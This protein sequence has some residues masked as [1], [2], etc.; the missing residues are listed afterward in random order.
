MINKSIQI[1]SSTQLYGVFG[2]PVAHSLSPVM[3]NRAFAET[4]VNGAYLA[5]EVTDIQAAVAGLRALGMRGASVTIPHKVRVM[6]YLDSVDETAARIGAVNTIVNDNGF[7]K[8]YNSD[9]LGAV[10][11][12][13]EKTPLNG[14]DVTILGAGGAA[15][16]IGFAVT[17]EGARVTVVNRTEERGKRL[18]REL[19]ADFRPLTGLQGLECEVL[20]NTTSVG[21]AP[22]ID[23]LPFDEELIERRALVMDIVYNPLK[24]KLLQR[25]EAIGCSTIDGV[26]MFVYQGGF[27]FELWTGR[28]APLA[29]MRRTVVDALTAAAVRNHATRG[30][31]HADH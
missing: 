8:G 6:D 31:S 2:N 26:A 13:G 28:P 21:M 5:F 10:R 9:G 30:K 23:A 29:L 11:A 20:I 19:G 12:L 1:D 27:Q 7:L 25:A 3:H 14:A 4:G 18:A 17:A 22:M 16:A 24:T 15:R